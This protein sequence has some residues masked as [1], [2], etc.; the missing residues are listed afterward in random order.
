MSSELPPD[1]H[2]DRRAPHVLVLGATG[3]LGHK[4]V[5]RL[6]AQGFRVSGTIRSSSIP[7]T[8]AARLALAGAHQILPNVDV[9][10]DS[11]LEA[12]IEAVGP[13]VVI[14]AVGVIKQLDLAKDA[15]TSIAANAMLPHRAAALCRKRGARLIQFSTD[16]VFAGRNGPFSENSPTDAEDIYG[17]SKLLGEVSGPGCLTI[18]SSIVGRELRGRSSLIEW[19]LSQRGGHAKGFAGALYTG[20]T[21]SAMSDLVANLMT[22]HPDV[23][24]VWHVASEPISKYELL[25]IVNAQYGLGVTL[26]RDEKFLCDRRLDGS[27]FAKRTGFRAPDW[28][29]M[30]KEMH[31]DPTPYDAH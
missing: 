30:I 8:P 4:L 9:L 24:G 25:Q 14:N 6:A 29:A 21:T 10:Q 22:D 12:A 20:L 17:R 27:N 18:R 1:P 2:T 26:E 16:C 7:D 3:M 5:Q 13:D 23:D 11:A 28:H 15:I 31:D 19:F